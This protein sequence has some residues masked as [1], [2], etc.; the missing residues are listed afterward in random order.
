LNIFDCTLAQKKG[1]KRRSSVTPLKKGRKN[2]CPRPFL[3]PGR[4]NK[5]ERRKRKRKELAPREK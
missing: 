2:S 4:S 5:K 1:K 3:L